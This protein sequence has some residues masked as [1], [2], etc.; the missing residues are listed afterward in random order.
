MIDNLSAM[1][2]DMFVVRHAQ[3]GAPHLIAQH[4]SARRGA[5]NGDKAT[6]DARMTAH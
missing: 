6:D 5:L 2:A 3:S 1:H 4:L